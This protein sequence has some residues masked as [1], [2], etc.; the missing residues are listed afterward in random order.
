[1]TIRQLASIVEK[2]VN[3]EPAT[4]NRSAVGAARLVCS[5]VSGFRFPVSDFSNF[6]GT[7]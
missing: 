1:M 3:R 7:R 6:G 2:D 4:G 5:Q